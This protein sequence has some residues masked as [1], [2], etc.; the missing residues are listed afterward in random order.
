MAVEDRVLEGKVEVDGMAV[1]A[2]SALMGAE[3]SQVV[4]FVV[5]GELAD[6]PPSGW[7]AWSGLEMVGNS[8]VMWP[9]FALVLGRENENGV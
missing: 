2:P 5:M 9:D 4:V 3:D 6:R 1:R 8:I 7:A